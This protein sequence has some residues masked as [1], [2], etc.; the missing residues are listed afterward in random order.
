MLVDIVKAVIPETPGSWNRSSKPG[1]L[2]GLKT[3]KAEQHNAKELS[4]R[5][6][7]VHKHSDRQ[8]LDIQVQ[9]SAFAIK[10]R[11]AKFENDR[12]TF[13][14]LFGHFAEAAQKVPKKGLN[15]PQ[16]SSR[17]NFLNN[18]GTA[19]FYISKS[20]FNYFLSDE[21]HKFCKIKIFGGL[22]GV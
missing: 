8:I 22:Q 2:P 7:E 15:L 9:R 4:R 3:T 19:N 6:P 12:I 10:W 21:L 14:A 11:H 20:R 18:Y 5:I 13:R 16:F 17:S 1:K